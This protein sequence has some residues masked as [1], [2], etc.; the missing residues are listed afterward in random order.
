MKPFF[1][2]QCNSC[3]QQQTDANLVRTRKKDDNLTCTSWLAQ[4]RGSQLV[5]AHPFG[6][7]LHPSS[8]S[9]I[10]CHVLVSYFYLTLNI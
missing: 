5:L 2:T 8:G 10:V 6:G 7:E 3:G 1:E 4:S 9:N